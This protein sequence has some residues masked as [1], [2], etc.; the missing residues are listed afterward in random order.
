LRCTTVVTSQ[1]IFQREME[2][3]IK[4]TLEQGGDARDMALLALKTLKRCTGLVE[5]F[6]K[7]HY[8]LSYDPATPE[9]QEAAIRRARHALAAR[10]GEGRL[11]RLTI[12]EKRALKRFGVADVICAIGA[13]FQPGPVDRPMV[14]LPLRDNP[15][16]AE[17]MSRSLESLSEAEK[18][19]LRRRLEEEG[20]SPL[21]RAI[22]NAAHRNIEN[23]ARADLGL[24]GI[25]DHRRRAVKTGRDGVVQPV[26]PDDLPESRPI[27]C[28][29]ETL[30][31]IAERNGFSR[32]QI[33]LLVAT[34]LWGYQQGEIPAFLGWTPKKVERISRSLS[35]DRDGQEL[36]TALIAA[37]WGR[38]IHARHR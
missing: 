14:P 1:L 32:D 36:H 19:M 23:F 8:G 10:E 34:K 30:K 9:Q 21:F 7:V 24:K 26:D 4:E 27:R 38:K 3:T 35:L 25:E 33:Q 11:K 2:R 28:D 12:A 18:R 15:Q 17:L 29:E 13:F 16:V 6:V 20:I 5:W 22:R 31:E 37:L